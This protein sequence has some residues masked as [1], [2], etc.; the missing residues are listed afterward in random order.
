MLFDHGSIAFVEQENIMIMGMNSQDFIF[1]RIDPT[2]YEVFDNISAPEGLLKNFQSSYSE[3]AESETESI[4]DFISKLL[5][6]IEFLSKYQ[7]IIE[8]LFLLIVIVG[9]WLLPREGMSR[10]QLSQLLLIN[11][12]TAADI[13]ELFEAFNE[14]EVADRTILKITILSCWQASLLQFCFNKTATRSKHVVRERYRKI[15]QQL[16]SSPQDRSI[17]DNSCSEPEELIAFNSVQEKETTCCLQLCHKN[18]SEPQKNNKNPK[19]RKFQKYWWM[20]PCVYRPFFC[21]ETELWAIVLSLVLQ[22]IPFFIVRM[23][24]ICMFEVSSYSNFFFTIKNGLIITVQIFRVFVILTEAGKS[25]EK[26]KK[27]KKMEGIVSAA[28]AKANKRI[29]VAKGPVLRKIS[30]LQTVNSIRDTNI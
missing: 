21:C 14:K 29:S 26:R 15:M 1:A 27:K 19:C 16:K 12:G 28:R 11:V 5:N 10:D 22:E 8:Q 9:R 4:G 13:L 18:R 23:T 25:D 30:S 3:N 2:Q 6:Q 24:L 7:R 20:N 17:C